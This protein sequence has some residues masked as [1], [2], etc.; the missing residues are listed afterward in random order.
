MPKNLVFIE[1]KAQKQLE[2]LPEETRNRINEALN[3][4]LD[5]DF[6]AELDIKKL[7]GTKNITASELENTEFSL[8]FQGIKQ[9]L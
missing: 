1:R 6:S 3:I 7:L 9:S 2:K 5:T 4:L 8:S